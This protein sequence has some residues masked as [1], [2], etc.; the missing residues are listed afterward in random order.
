MGRVLP[1]RGVPTPRPD[2]APT[3]QT[4]NFDR[5]TAARIETIGSGVTAIG[6]GLHLQTTDNYVVSAKTRL[7]LLIA[8]LTGH[9]GSM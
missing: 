9:L 4:I 3:G 6:R 7:A 2:P 8:E 5:L 1:M